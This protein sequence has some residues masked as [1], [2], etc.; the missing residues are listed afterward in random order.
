MYLSSII[1]PLRIDHRD[2]FVNAEIVLNY[3]IKYCSNMKIYVIENGKQNHFQNMKIENKQ[4][5]EYTFQYND[6]QLFHR[7]KIINEL[8]ACVHTKNTFIYDIDCLLPVSTFI[9]VEEM[10]EY[11]QIVKPFSNPP[12]CVYIHPSNKSNIMGDIE[13]YALKQGDTTGFAGN[14]FIVCVDTKTYKEIGGENELF[15]AYGPEDNERYYRFEKL[16]YVKGEIKNN[17]YHLEHF[18]TPNS[19]HNNPY[20]KDN[21]NL[22]EKIKRMS[23]EELIEYY[24]R[25]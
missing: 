12:G 5:I 24:R 1:I 20:F 11:C 18:R 15:K 3:L 8:L 14:G 7:M 13:G 2:R 10:L 19:S 16:G 4:S 6:E 22:F 21:N 23:K 9:K 17:V 25:I